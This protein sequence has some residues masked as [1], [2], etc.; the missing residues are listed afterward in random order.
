M[1]KGAEVVEEIQLMMN[2]NYLKLIK[3]RSQELKILVFLLL[4]KE[5]KAKEKVFNC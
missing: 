4:L 5:L 1:I 3:E 2:H